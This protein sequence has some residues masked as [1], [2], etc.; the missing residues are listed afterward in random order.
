MYYVSRTYLFNSYF[1]FKYRGLYFFN[2]FS[3]S[4][5]PSWLCAFVEH[6][7]QQREHHH[8]RRRHKQNQCSL[9]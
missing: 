9:G 5:F 3:F 8:L 2:P 4:P 6:I 1:M 7:R